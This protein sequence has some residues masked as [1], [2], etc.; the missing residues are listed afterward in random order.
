MKPDSRGW[1]TKILEDF[2][3]VLEEDTELERQIRTLIFT[4]EELERLY[5]CFQKYYPKEVK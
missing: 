2:E 3:N 5:K 4:D 1:K